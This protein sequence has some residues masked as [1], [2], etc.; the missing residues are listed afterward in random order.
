MGLEGVTIGVGSQKMLWDFRDYG[1]PELWVKRFRLYFQRA[2]YA[3]R[4]VIMLELGKRT[5]LSMSPPV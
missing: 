2:N 3:K 1:L 5:D 4:Y